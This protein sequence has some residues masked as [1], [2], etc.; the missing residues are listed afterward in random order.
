M[1]NRWKLTPPRTW[2]VWRPLSPVTSWPLALCDARSVAPNDLVKTDIIR[3]RF[4]GETCFA[5]YNSR[6]EWYYISGQRPDEVAMLKIFD[7]DA[8]VRAK[9]EYLVK[10]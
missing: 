10:C 4:V 5:T 9:C 8:D 6:H 7:S 3:K 2:S 1:V